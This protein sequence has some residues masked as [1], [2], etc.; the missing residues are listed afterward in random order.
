MIIVLFIAELK[1]Q[2]EC[3][4]KLYTNIDSALVNPECVKFLAIY[5]YDVDTIDI[6][7]FSNLKRISLYD[8]NPYN[9]LKIAYKFD[10]LELIKIELNLNNIPE[11][12]GYCKNLKQLHLQRVNITKLPSSIGNLKNLE[13]LN[14]NYSKLEELPE[15]IT[16]LKKMKQIHISQCPLDTKPDFLKEMDCEIYIYKGE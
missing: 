1:S 12:I 2:I 14:I 9:F 4:E 7:K 15:E 8:S 13:F 3:L 6:L 16:N 10:S 11:E 5:H